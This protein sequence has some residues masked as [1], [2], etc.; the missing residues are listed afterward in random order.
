MSASF[1][2]GTTQSKSSMEPYLRRNFGSPSSTGGAIEAWI[3]APRPIASA[4]S[5]RFWSSR[6]ASIWVRIAPRLP[7]GSLMSLFRN[8]FLTHFFTP[9]I[10]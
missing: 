5:I 4:V 7:S 10:R 6:S 3:H 2:R 9:A 8:P 1:H